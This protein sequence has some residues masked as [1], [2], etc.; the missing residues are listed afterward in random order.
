MTAA[1]APRA[2]TYFSELGDESRAC[3]TSRFRELEGEADEVVQDGHDCS[4][5]VPVACVDRLASRTN[6]ISSTTA[7]KMIKKRAREGR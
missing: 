4:G 5:R 2:D 3:P 7:Y 1:R 6:R